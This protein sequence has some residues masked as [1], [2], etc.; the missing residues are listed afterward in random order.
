ML[1]LVLV[2]NDAIEVTS[3]EVAQYDAYIYTENLKS[4]SLEECE[5]NCQIVECVCYAVGKS[6]DDEKRNSKKKR[7]EASLAGKVYR[8]CH[9]ETAADA[10][11]TASECASLESEFKNLLCS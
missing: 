11:K 1:I 7:N 8:S 6:A 2:K 3:D 5:R 10:K 4:M 9:E